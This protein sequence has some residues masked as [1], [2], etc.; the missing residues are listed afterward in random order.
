MPDRPT[1]TQ[2]GSAS[3]AARRDGMQAQ[4]GP[5]AGLALDRRDAEVYARWFHALSDP[6][7]VIILS[8]LARQHDPVPVGKVVADL[9]IGQSTVS[10]H[11]RILFEV[12]FVARARSHANRLYAVNR[13]CITR[14]PEA[15]EL[16]MGQPKLPAGLDPAR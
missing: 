4:P 8:Y 10:R 6:T 12:G 9:G 15:A 3:G 14:F 5:G 1:V 13:N 2:P 11:L 7:R 16:I